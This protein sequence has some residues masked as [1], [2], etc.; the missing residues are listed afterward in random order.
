VASRTPSSETAWKGSGGGVSEYWP[1]PQW[2]QAAVSPANTGSKCGDF[3][4]SCRE[5]PDVALDANPNT[6]YMYYCT[7]SAAVCG[8]PV[9]WLAIGGTSASSPLMAGITADANDAAG[10]D[11]GF[12][13]PFLYSQDGTNVFHD[14]RSGTNSVTGGTA[15]TAGPGY[16]MVTGLGSVDAQHLATALHTHGPVHVG[17][18]HTT[19]LTPIRPADSLSIRYGTR[20]TFTGTL[21]DTGGPVHEGLVIIQLS[22]GF[23]LGALSESNGHFAVHGQAQLNRNLTWRAVY[24]GSDTE[25][26]SITPAARLYVTPTLSAGLVGTRSSGVYHIAVATR[27]E[28]K[29]HALPNMHGARMVAQSRAGS[30]PWHTLASATVN[31]RGKFHTY[32]EFKRKRS[33]HLRWVFAGGKSKHWLAAVSPAIA[34]LVR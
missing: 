27:H 29:G 15:Y 11:L 21:T 4:D 19:T 23:E 34:V 7:V 25:A 8:S 20:V 17:A 28:F 6:G 22:N 5:S 13:S 33:L 16:D 32:L 24:L 14:I 1:M 9:G 26:P 10:V 30:G 2:Q 3:V 31:A 18:P 12:A